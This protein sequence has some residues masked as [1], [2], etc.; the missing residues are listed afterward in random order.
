MSDLVELISSDALASILGVTK[1]TAVRLMKSSDIR[2]VTD[3]KRNYVTR[4]E[5]TR[6]LRD[7]NLMPAPP[8]HPRITTSIPKI[9]ALSFFSGALGLDLGMEQGGITPLLY[10]EFD[11][12]CRMTINAN[13]PDQALVGDI[14]KLNAAEVRRM[15]RIPEGRA[16]DVMFGGPPCQA[17]STAGARRAFNDWRGNVFLKFLDL[18]KELAPTYLVIEN[19]RGLLSARWPLSAGN[20][21][22][23]GGALHLI[24]RTLSDMG[25]STSFELYNAAN[26]GAPQIRE[27][28]ILIAKKDSVPVNHLMPT[29]SNDPKWGLPAWRTF[30][31]A[32]AGLDVTNCH[33]S[34]FPENRLKYLRLIS[35]GQ[36]WKDLPEDVQE[37][38]MGKSYQL[39]G[40]KTGFYRRIRF[41]RPCPTLVT[42]PTMP[43]TYLCHPIEDRPLSVEEYRRVQGFPDNWVI[44]GDVN[45]QYKQ[46]GNA[47]PVA[48]GTAV[49]N[50]LLHDMNGVEVQPPEGFPY[51]RYKR[52][53]ESTWHPQDK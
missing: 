14:T 1:P 37:E 27:R 13:R 41:D 38:A 30:G 28:V 51:S 32:V 50:T 9:V 7:N 17:F 43:A 26:F 23:K 22:V 10:C 31:E 4:E 12:K 25:Y 39:P 8:D 5:I 29:N 21:P 47:V 6:Y 18:A 52:T 33:H 48:L 15:A 53:S 3:G 35:A 40:G 42:S 16:V 49:A 19:V 44:C 11:R 20:T 34:E 46:I 2:T 24:L 36:Y 45:D